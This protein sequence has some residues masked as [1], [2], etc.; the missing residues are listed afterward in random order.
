MKES[1]MV[2]AVELPNPAGKGLVS[3]RSTK[4]HTEHATKILLLFPSFYSL[5]PNLVR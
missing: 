4:E 3:Q 1:H 2:A 5:T